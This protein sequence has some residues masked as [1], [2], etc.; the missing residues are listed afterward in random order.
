MWQIQNVGYT[1]KQLARTVNLKK[2]KK[3]TWKELKVWQD[4]F[5]DQKKANRC[6]KQLQCANVD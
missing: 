3:S 6:D 5:L 2:K 4:T 1:T